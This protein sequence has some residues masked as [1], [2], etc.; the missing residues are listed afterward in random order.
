M[1]WKRSVIIRKGLLV[2]SL[3]CSAAFRFSF[4]QTAASASG[5]RF[6]GYVEGYL[7]WRTFVY[8]KCSYYLDLDEAVR[9]RQTD[10]YSRKPCSRGIRDSP[11]RRRSRVVM[12]TAGREGGLNGTRRISALYSLQCTYEWEEWPLERRSRGREERSEKRERELLQRSSGT[13][14]ECRIQ[15]CV[16]LGVCAGGG[17]WRVANHAS[18]NIWIWNRT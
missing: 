10:R 1:L 13:R 2:N 6:A 14:R 8:T 12:A 4:G 17:G 11:V 5:S 16:Q 7:S 3:T 15:F 9:Y 18:F